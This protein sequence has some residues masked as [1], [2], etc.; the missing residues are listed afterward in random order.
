MKRV[1]LLLALA[2][3]VTVAIAAEP[4]S[5]N[6]QVTDAHVILN[7]TRVFSC[8]DP[9]GSDR[10][11][12]DGESRFPVSGELLVQVRKGVCEKH[13]YS[14]GGGDVYRSDDGLSQIQ[15]PASIDREVSFKCNAQGSPI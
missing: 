10:K 1:T 11:C 14:M 8:D 7:D 15:F 4:E 3:I 6:A 2:S 5:A 12:V 13:A 9:K